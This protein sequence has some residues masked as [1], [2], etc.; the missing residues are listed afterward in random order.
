MQSQEGTIL[1]H[2]LLPWQSM[3]VWV[4]IKKKFIYLT[5]LEAKGAGGPISSASENGL[6]VTG[7][8]AEAVEEGK[9]T[10]WD[11]KPESFRSQ[12]CSF[13]TYTCGNLVSQGK[14]LPHLSFLKGGFGKLLSQYC[15]EATERHM[16]SSWQGAQHVVHSQYRNCWSSDWRPCTSKHPTHASGTLASTHFLLAQVWL[17]ELQDVC[18]ILF[19]EVW[20]K[21]QGPCTC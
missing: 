17:K 20:G 9:I 4:C 13:I 12:A 14:H 18:C 3:W 21:N 11:R 2:F 19:F 10:W 7:T 16:H 1:V 8:M 15:W 5:I 6:M